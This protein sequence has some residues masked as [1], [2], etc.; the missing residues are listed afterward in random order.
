[1]KDYFEYQVLVPN[2]GIVYNF[3][4]DGVI[5]IWDA[6]ASIEDTF[7]AGYF[8][9]KMPEAVMVEVVKMMIDAGMNVNILSSAYDNGKAIP[10]KAG[11]L[12]KHIGKKGYGRTFVPYGEDK[13]IYMPHGQ[14]NVLI[15]DFSKNLH[16]WVRDTKE[17]EKNLAFKFYNGINGNH[18]TWTSYAVTNRMTAEEIYTEI[19]SI[20]EKIA[21]SNVSSNLQMI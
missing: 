20:S 19:V 21:K 18:G 16:S 6:T 17:G 15:D 5:A 9:S 3:D 2:G 13:T 10:E 11:W 7:S 12:D 14:V 1:M 8:A 4:M